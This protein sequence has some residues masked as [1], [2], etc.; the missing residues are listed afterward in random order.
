MSAD[1]PI[2]PVFTGTNLVQRGLLDSRAKV[3]LDLW[4]RP[5]DVVL[6]QPLISL[7]AGIMI[8]IWPALLNYVVAAFLIVSGI[9][10]LL[11]QLQNG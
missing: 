10:G 1:L 6:I 4:E 11:P 5:M 3:P 8:L 7:V 2:L 9:L